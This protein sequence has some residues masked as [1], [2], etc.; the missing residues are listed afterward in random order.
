MLDEF[1]PFIVIGLASG[2]V[3]G[4][5]GL[6]LVLTY[7]TSGI[8]NFGFG[9]VAALS[10]FCFYFLHVDQGMSW[11]VAAVI[12]VAVLGSV[13]GVAMELLARALARASETIKVVATVGLIL[14]ILA[15]GR[16]WHEINPPTFPH[17][18]PTSVVRMFGV[19]ITWEQIILF[20]FC[21]VVSALLY[22]FFQSVRLGIVMRAIVDSPDLVSMSGD[23]PTTVRRWAWII[24]T[25]FAAIAGLFLAPGQ[26]VDGISLTVL[27]FAA[28][29]AA[30]I[31]YFDNLPLTFAGGLIIGVA[32]ALF[33]K[34]AGTID[35]VG[36]LPPSLPFVILF[37]VLIIT[38]RRRLVRRRVPTQ[39]NVQRPYQAPLRIRFVAGA[40]AIGLLALVPL[41]QEARLAVW[42]RALIDIMLFL[43]LGILVRYCGQ[44]SLCHLAFAAVGAA[45]F[46]HFTTDAGLPWLL[47]V[48][49]AT[50]VA[51]PVGALIA[52][53]AVRVSGVFLALAT[54]GFGILA[55]YVFYSRGFMFGS[56]AFGIA[57]PRP[58]FTVFGT[59]L[60]SDEGFYY[61]L[62][63]ITVLVT[64]GLTAITSGRLGRLLRAMG[65]SQLALETRGTNSTILKVIVF[66]LTAAV[67]SLAGSLIGMLDHFAVGTSFQPF[68]SMTLVV[69]VAIVAFGAPWFAVMAAVGHGVISGYVEGGNVATWLLLLFG[70]TG[71]AAVY[72]TRFGRM[73]RPLREFLDRVGGRTRQQSLDPATKDAPVT[74]TAHNRE[75]TLTREGLEVR[76]LSVTFGG[77][78]AVDD[79]S[80]RA[81]MAQITGLIGPNGAGKTTTFNVCSGLLR[82]RRGSVLFDG[83]DVT[84]ESPSRRARRGLGRTFQRPELFNSLTVQQNVSMGREASMAGSRLLTQLG[85]SRRS[86]RTIA[87]ATAEALSITGTHAIAD[88]QVGLLPIGQRRLVELATVLAGPFDLL[89]LDEPSSGLDG[90]ETESFGRILKTVVE[91]WGTGIFLV[92]HDM[93]LVRFVCDRVYVLDFGSKIFEGTP[94]EMDHSDEVRAAY[95]GGTVDGSKPRATDQTRVVEPAVPR[96]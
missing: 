30:A 56:N 60:A 86:S 53:P 42:S 14:I 35:W 27:V 72:G 37:V 67:A 28:F 95:L 5:A 49:L 59:D 38:P 80:L 24:G 89:L 64:V 63:F 79:L 36:G 92:E 39:E 17:F 15:I 8:F 22:W 52:V 77:V 18:L 69:L 66:C 74:T 23:D 51:I 10:A 48:V 26:Q 65:D 71:L 70:V 88:V 7:K 54:L 76:N 33:D 57:A 68:D 45:A 20:V 13:V 19:N 11:P 50:L 12:T 87:A 83:V 75:A 91:E 1:L 55:Q 61:L 46:G 47:A 29:G 2:A 44:I 25:V 43:S 93:T 78:A 85:G 96:D 34:Y 82:P 94:E 16:F 6:G 9:A 21:V 62:L 32:T 3:Y 58:D 81:P 73:P 40:V 84:R 4:L 41:F 31:G 90:N